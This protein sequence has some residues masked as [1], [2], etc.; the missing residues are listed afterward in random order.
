V[1][2]NI[3]ADAGDPSGAKRASLKVDR[4]FEEAAKLSGTDAPPSTFFEQLLKMTLEAID[5]P[6]GAIWLK[7]PQGFLQLQCQSNIEQVGLDKHK[8][9][10]QSHN[11]LLRQ[12]FQTAKPILLE[13]FGSTG[14]LEGIPAGNP[15][16]YVVLLAPILLEENK[17]LGLIE[18]WQVP[19]FDARSKRVQL[20]FAVQMAGYASTYFRNQHGRS[21]LNQEHLWTQLEAFACQIHATLDTTIVAYHVANEGRR[22]IGCDRLSVALRD[23]KKAKIE[24][25]SG[26]DVVEKRA[27]QIKLMRKLSKS[28]F[29]WDEKLVYRGV[30]DDG[31][32]PD[33][34]EALDKYL[35]ESNAKLLVLQPLR[36]PREKDKDTKEYR[37]G[38]ARSALLMECF[39]PPV[40]PEPLFAKLD[41]I[42]RHASSALYNAA[43]MKNIPLA[44]LW[45]PVLMVQEGLGGKTRLIT[46]LS[47]ALAT[48]VILALV[49]V[50]YE[51][52]MDAKGQMLPLD[53]R[54]VYAPHAG[55]I[56]RFNVDSN[57]V[58]RPGG[59]LIEMF[60]P[61][62]EMKVA[63]LRSEIES[64]SAKVTQMQQQI[65]N[66]RDVTDRERSSM[67]SRDLTQSKIKLAS[68]QRELQ[69]L[70]NAFNARADRVG[71]F[72]VKAPESLADS[73]RS[74]A[75]E[76]IVLSGNDFKGDLQGKY[77]KPDFPLLQLGDRLGAWE[78]EIKIPQKN[79]GQVIGAFKNPDDPNEE[80]DVDLKLE[81][82]PNKTFRGKLAR[83]KIGPE[84]IP[85]KDDHNETEPVV[86]AYVRTSGDDIAA[87]DR[88][89]EN[90]LLKGV[91][92]RSKVRCGQHPLG[93]CLFYGVWDFI[94]DKIFWAF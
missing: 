87:G 31:L 92:V 90:L 7:N 75:P 58:V 50:P 30:K 62:L 61:E 53:R 56:V 25:V 26:A 5:A 40:Q 46:M 85:N 91:E 12:A 45:K 32:P 44:L 49:L 69:R 9:G 47:T 36:D 13:P 55:N 1:N 16:D 10:R 59:V 78:V 84:A 22:L 19:Q 34:Y 21:S 57:S 66:Y 51:L 37:P 4:A 35:A 52:K 67:V 74:K 68:G 64:E 39:E 72:F 24:A 73:R 3:P 65:L 14:I 2:P 82:Y 88:I 93:Y 20:N 48:L 28:V 54:T 15:T 77:A 29:K 81:S 71:G 41:V 42:G 38:K 86:Y 60:D 63:Q 70:T 33:V 23:G 18:I 11:E 8:N 94:C 80:V 43:Q 83:H 76:W 17:A 6:A 27:T 79:I 89:P